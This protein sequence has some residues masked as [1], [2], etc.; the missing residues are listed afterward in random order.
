M[1]QWI[2]SKTLDSRLRGNE[3]AN[4]SCNISVLCRLR[5]FPLHPT[6]SALSPARRFRALLSPPRRWGTSVFAATPRT[7]PAGHPSPKSAIAAIPS[8]KS[9]ADRP[10]SAAQDI[11]RSP[12]I[13]RNHRARRNK[14]RCIHNI[15]QARRPPN[16]F[17]RWLDI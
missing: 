12:A 6:A 5:C 3:I 2:R 7:P 16:Q 9:S 15:S 17:P 10:H 1:P 4:H 14:T 13:A 8:S 11:S